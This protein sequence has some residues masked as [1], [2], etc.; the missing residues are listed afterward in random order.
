MCCQSSLTKFLDYE[1]SKD[2]E[3]YSGRTGK[4]LAIFDR[5]RNDAI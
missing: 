3:V 5:K 4:E 1:G 2:R